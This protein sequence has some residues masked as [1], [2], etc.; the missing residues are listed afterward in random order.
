MISQNDLLKMT[1][2]DIHG[3]LIIHKRTSELFVYVSKTL[4]PQG[5]FAHFHERIL[6]IFFK[7]K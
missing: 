1:D 2:N 7:I 3:L 4:F 5:S 6:L